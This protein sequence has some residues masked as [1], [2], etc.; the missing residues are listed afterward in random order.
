[1][2]TR[3]GVS[4]E[5]TL[6][7]KFDGLIRARGY[8]NRSEAI[9]DLVRNALVEDEWA[10]GDGEVA[11]AVTLVYDHHVRGLSNALTEIQHRQHHLVVS[12][13]HVHLDEHNCLEV[14]V[15][16]GGVEEIRGMADALISARGVKHGR[17]V[18][19]SL[20]RELS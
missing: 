11:G 10:G 13:T 7:E 5:N 4:M 6:L 20:G 2:L 8:A 18:M 15:V 19:T 12:V 16:R 3:F 9:R 1:M 17:L 14:L